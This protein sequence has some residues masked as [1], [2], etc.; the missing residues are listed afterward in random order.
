M[1]VWRAF[2]LDSAFPA[3]AFPVSLSYNFQLVMNMIRVAIHTVQRRVHIPHLIYSVCICILVR[4]A[5]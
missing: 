1:L 3:F 2:F 4:G 5:V